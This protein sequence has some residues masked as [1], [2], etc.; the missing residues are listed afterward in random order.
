MNSQAC[1]GVASRRVSAL[2]SFAIVSRGGGGH[3]IKNLMDENFRVGVTR[4]IKCTP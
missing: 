1:I 4:L 3:F 2:P